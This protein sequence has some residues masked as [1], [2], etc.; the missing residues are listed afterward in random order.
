MLNLE[1]TKWYTGLFTLFVFTFALIPEN[2]YEI[3]F[4][5]NTVYQYIVLILVFGFSLSLILC[6]N[7]KYYILEKKKGAVSI[8][9]AS[10]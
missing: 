9:K 10:I 8:D 3:I 5:E 7:I 1:H 4:I 2:M 6:A